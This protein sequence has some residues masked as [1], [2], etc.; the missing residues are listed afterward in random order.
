MIKQLKSIILSKN[1]V[2]QMYED[3]KEEI[4]AVYRIEEGQASNGPQYSTYKTKD[5]F[6]L[7]ICRIASTFF[8]LHCIAYYVYIFTIRSK[9][10]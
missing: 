1:T 10:Y 9:Y 5:T 8:Q 3:I 4:K 2:S 7:V 6:A